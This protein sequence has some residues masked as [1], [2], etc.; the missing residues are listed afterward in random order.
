MQA[1]VEGLSRAFLDEGAH[2]RQVHGFGGA[3]LTAPRIKAFQLFITTRQEVVQAESLVIQCCNRGAATRT[4]PAVSI[5][6]H[7]IHSTQAHGFNSTNSFIPLQVFLTKMRYATHKVS[8]SDC[9]SCPVEHSP[10]ALISG[11]VAGTE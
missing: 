2:G 4:H 3:E 9:N 10:S 8:S 5:R 11:C 7:R 6:K 1:D